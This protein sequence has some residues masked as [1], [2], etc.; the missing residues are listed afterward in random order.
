MV[1]DELHGKKRRFKLQSLPSG[2]QGDIPLISVLLVA[3]SRFLH[4]SYSFNRTLGCQAWPYR[5][6]VIGSTHCFRT[7]VFRELESVVTVEPKWSLEG[8]FPSRA[9][10]KVAARHETRCKEREYPRVLRAYGPVKLRQSPLIFWSNGNHCDGS[11]GYG[12][13]DPRAESPG[14]ASRDEVFHFKVAG[15]SRLERSTTGSFCQS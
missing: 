11:T 13:S 15:M 3:Q 7:T 12:R 5:L 10:F 2:R 6:A 8:V 14:H 9:V 4:S 1:N